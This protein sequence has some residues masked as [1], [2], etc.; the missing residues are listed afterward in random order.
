LAKQRNNTELRRLIDDHLV[1]AHVLRTETL[2][3]DLAALC[4][5]PLRPYLSHPDQALT[6]LDVVPPRNSSKSN[7]FRKQDV[8][9]NTRNSIIER[10]W[11]LMERYF[12]DQM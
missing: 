6:V 1:N 4:K 7:Q 8:P 2:S 10:E 9:D 3:A 12:S 5:G 11:A